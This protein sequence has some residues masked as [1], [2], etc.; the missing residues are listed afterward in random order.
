[1]DQ[2]IEETAHKETQ[3]PGRTKGHSFKSGAVARY[4]ITADYRRSSVR[5]IREMVGY[6]TD[7][8]W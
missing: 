3:T 4:S 5:I 6:K 2:A 7:S 1:M 8:T